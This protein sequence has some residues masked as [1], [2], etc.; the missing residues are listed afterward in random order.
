[1]IHPVPLSVRRKARTLIADQLDR[2]GRHD[3]ARKTR[4]G[5]RD[6]TATE[7]LA[8]AVW[9]SA[10]DIAKAEVKGGMAG[11]LVGMAIGFLA[12]YVLLV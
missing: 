8:A 5:M 4:A 1:M 11:V 3:D 12:A 6:N 2:E 9:V 10:Q 7:V